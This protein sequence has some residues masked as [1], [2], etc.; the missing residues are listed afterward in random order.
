MSDSAR[1]ARERYEYAKKQT[2]L[3]GQY[4]SLTGRYANL[5]DAERSAAADLIEAVEKDRDNWRKWHGEWKDR[6]ERTE[7]ERDDWEKQCE[8]HFAEIRSVIDL[9]IPNK[10]V[11]RACPGGG[12]EEVFAT[13]ALSAGKWKQAHEFAEFRAEE[14]ERRARIGVDALESVLMLTEGK[15]STNNAAQIAKMCHEAIRDI[16]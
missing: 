7:A 8:S 11:V 10:Y 16:R 3:E 15:T 9:M 4:E 1:S 6:A 13:L 14:M 12:A 5:R 2:D